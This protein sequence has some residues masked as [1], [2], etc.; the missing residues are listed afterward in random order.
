MRSTPDS[1]DLSHL[2]EVQGTTG[3]KQ[4][5]PDDL[6]ALRALFLLLD[7]W[8]RNNKRATP[9]DMQ[10]ESEQGERHACAVSARPQRAA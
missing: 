9:V 8:D 2:Q 6:L 3:G 7:A 4:L 5:T 1:T 10:T